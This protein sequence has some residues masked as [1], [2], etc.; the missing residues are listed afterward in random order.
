[1]GQLLLSVTDDLHSS[2]T[3]VD[4]SSVWAAIPLEVGL[5]CAARILIELRSTCSARELD[6]SPKV[7]LHDAIFACCEAHECKIRMSVVNANLIEELGTLT[8]EYDKWGGK[9]F[10]TASFMAGYW[11]LGR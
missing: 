4:C 11:E 9:Q 7:L 1:M 2:F 8:V 5:D 6:G 3:C 10:I